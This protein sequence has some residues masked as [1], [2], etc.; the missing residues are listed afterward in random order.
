M[1]K[2][3]SHT[4]LIRLP[5]LDPATLDTVPAKVD[6]PPLD[7]HI[8]ALSFTRDGST[9]GNLRRREN[10]ISCAVFVEVG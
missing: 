6:N 8:L 9:S 10:T 3:K 7:V 1:L 4:I 5:R 2:T